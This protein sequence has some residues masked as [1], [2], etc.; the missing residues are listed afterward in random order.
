MSW[1]EVGDRVFVRRYEFYDQNIGVV[2]GRDEALVIDTR[3]THV[4]AREI[5]DDLREL[6]A[7]PVTVVVDTHGHFDHAF[8]NHVFR[9]ATIWGHERLRHLPRADGRG[10]ARE[11]RR[12]SAGDRGRH[13]RGRRRPARPD[14]RRDRPRRGRRA[15]RR[16]PSPRAR[17]HRP[18]HRHLGAG[19]RRPVR[20][21]PARERRRPVVRRRLPARL[22]GDGAARRGAGD[23]G[24][25]ARAMATTPD[26]R[27]RRTRRRPSS[28]S[29]SSPGASIGVS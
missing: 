7:D 19:D 29:P 26:G 20:G 9:P 28:R 21:R 16:A 11:G 18:R 17:P 3:S 14:V 1:V 12:G 23:R 10:A 5:L 25:G 8:G 6:T 24:R 4:Q 22:A 15:A 2:L 13:R 27:S